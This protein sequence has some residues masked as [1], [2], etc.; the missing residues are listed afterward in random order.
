MRVVVA[1]GFAVSVVL[2]AGQTA[3]ADDRGDVVKDVK[4][5]PEAVRVTLVKVGGEHTVASVTG[6]GTG[7]RGCDWSVVFVDELDEATYG[8]DFGAKPHPDARLALLL[9]NG[10]IVQPIWVAPD[11]IVDVDAAARDEAE[12][13]IE[14]V[15][16]P[17]VSIGVNPAARGLVGLD[18]WFWI[19]GFDGQVTAPPI[20]A[21][22]LTIEV[23]M[24]SGTVQWDF[25]D[26]TH[27]TG[28]LGR[29]YPEESTVRHVHQ[30]DGSFTITAAIDLVPEYRVDGGPW[31]TLPDLQAVATTAHAVEERQAVVTET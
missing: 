20:S 3:S 23:R 4:T 21:F 9:C 11:D 26:G 14:D 2:G 5:I 31:I 10:T 18:S 30:H 27:E 1:L 7:Q 28:D 15:L 19:E 29:A 17:A 22:G 8:T 25:G 13:Y 24:S 12:R 6:G 16:V